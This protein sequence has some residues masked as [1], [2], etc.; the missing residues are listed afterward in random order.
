MNDEQR[1]QVNAAVDAAID[2]KVKANRITVFRLDVLVH[3]A[4][5]DWLDKYQIAEAVG[6]EDLNAPAWRAQH[7]AQNTFARLREAYG[8]LVIGTWTM[9]TKVTNT[10]PDF[11]IESGVAAWHK[12]GDGVPGRMRLDYVFDTLPASKFARIRHLLTADDLAEEELPSEVIDE[13]TGRPRKFG[14][15]YVWKDENNL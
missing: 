12:A 4:W 8:L 10:T 11:E 15:A 6:W 3:L 7:E 14:G 2:N 5:R 13:A 1:K 9:K